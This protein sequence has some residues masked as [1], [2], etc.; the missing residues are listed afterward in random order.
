M[1]GIQA[2]YY[3]PDYQNNV[4]RGQQTSQQQS[5]QFY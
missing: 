5:E 3:Q 1:C 2:L 4:F